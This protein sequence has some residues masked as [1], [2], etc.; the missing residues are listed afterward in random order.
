M[1]E[2]SATNTRLMQR[3]FDKHGVTGVTAKKVMQ[4]SRGLDAHTLSKIPHSVRQILGFNEPE[5]Y[6]DPFQLTGLNKDIAGVSFSKPRGSFGA[7]DEMAKKVK[8]KPK[9]KM[10]KVTPA[11]YKPG[12]MAV[13]PRTGKRYNLKAPGQKFLDSSVEKKK[14]EGLRS[15]YS[16][17]MDRREDLVGETTNLLAQTGRHID[18][19]YEV[20]P[21]QHQKT[22]LVKPQKKLKDKTIMGPVTKK[23]PEKQILYERKVRKAHPLTS[24]VPGF[25]DLDTGVNLGGGYKGWSR[26]R[27]AEHQGDA[28]AA[29]EDVT[30]LSGVPAVSAGYTKAHKIPHGGHH[31]LDFYKT[32][33]MQHYTPWMQSEPEYRERHREYGAGYSTMSRREVDDRVKEIRELNEYGDKTQLTHPM[34]E[35]ISPVGESADHMYGQ[36]KFLPEK[37]KKKYRAQLV[38]GKLNPLQHEHGW[39]TPHP[40][41]LDMYAA[42]PGSDEDLEQYLYNPRAHDKMRDLINKQKSV[43]Y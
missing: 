5:G 26:H 27:G 15:S 42:Q 13:N 2:K 22:E 39:Q 1:V 32:D 8:T 38:K 18:P 25:E 24:N 23:G 40:S 7:I 36:A 28:F 17:V 14:I 21:V 43:H 10:K 3:I 29:D 31:Y 11:K 19:D 41:E 30:F 4:E 16:A 33:D 6:V 35:R 9:A 20:I 12:E 34:Y 37:I